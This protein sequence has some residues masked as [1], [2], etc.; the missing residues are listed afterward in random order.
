MEYYK[1]S[2]KDIADGVR[3]KKWSA[4]EVLTSFLDRIEKYDSK[5]NAVVT[6]CEKQA[7]EDANRIDEAVVRGEK[8]GLLAGVP[9]LVDDNFCTDEIKT[10]CGSK[11]LQDW[12]PCYDAT[13][14]RYMKAA[15]AVLMGKTNIDEFGMGS[16]TENFL[17]GATLNPH[18]LTC[19]PGG[20]S[21][22]SAAAVAAGYCPIALASDT[23]GS[24]RHPSAF[25]GVHG[26]KP[27]YGQVSRYGIVGYV[28]SL[29]QVGPITRNIEDM[30]ITMEI[31]AKSDAND[32]TCD[33]YD[34]PSF[35]DAGKTVDLNR[36]KIGLLTGFDRISV[37]NSLIEAIDKV[38]NLCRKSGAEIIEVTLPIMMKHTVAC[39]H[40][41][42]L[43]D[44]SSKLACYDGMRYGYHEDGK[45]LSDMYKKTRSKGFGD[46]VRRRILMGTCILTRDYFENYYIPVTKVRQ[47]IA[48]EYANLFK[49]V[50]AIIC[51][52]SPTLPHKTGF[53][54]EDSTK[55]YLRDLFSSTANLVGLP[56]ISLN[57]GVTPEGLPTNIQL[58]GPRF[59]DDKLL[60]LASAIEKHV[61]SPYVTDFSAKGGF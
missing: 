59:G 36:K 4:K 6:L 19:I 29:D 9:F 12:V 51:P 11:M 40:M 16:T 24:T 46:E 54:E 34:R 44:A 14:I 50:D 39:Y 20:G 10:T 57:V 15:G 58:I 37:E 56:S 26:M 55:I 48:D 22:G 60:S 45:N 47:M 52:I 38:V 27:S 1:L 21:G 42:A 5:L 30:G 32:S 53:L 31:I 61:G 35:S 8:L 17:F 13:V 23:G 18:D 3:E 2:A 25:C 28:S 41:I 43:G 7:Y 49:T 33:S